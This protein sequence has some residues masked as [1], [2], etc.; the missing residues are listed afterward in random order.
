MHGVTRDHADVTRNPDPH[1]HA[2]DIHRQNSMELFRV[3]WMPPRIRER[4][5]SHPS[6]MPRAMHGDARDHAE[7]YQEARLTL[8]LLRSFVGLPCR[9]MSLHGR[10]QYL[11]SL[12]TIGSTSVAKHSMAGFI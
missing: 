7:G 5:R 9:S 2:F 11:P 1:P 6:G 4:E 8:S 10:G 12:Q 3:V